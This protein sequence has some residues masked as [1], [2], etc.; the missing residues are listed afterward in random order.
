MKKRKTKETGGAGLPMVAG[1]ERL[2]RACDILSCDFAVAFNV[3]EN[4]ILARGDVAA[5]LCEILTCDAAFNDGDIERELRRIAPLAIAERHKEMNAAF[6]LHNDAPEITESNIEDFMF[7][8]RLEESSRIARLFR[9]IE[10]T[11]IQYTNDPQEIRARETA[12]I[13]EW[14]TREL[15]RA[16]GQWLYYSRAESIAEMAGELRRECAAKKWETGK[17]EVSAAFVTVARL[18][19]IAFIAKAESRQGAAHGCEPATGA[20]NPSG[21]AGGIVINAPIVKLNAGKVETPAP[22]EKPA[23][24]SKGFSQADFAALLKHY[25]GRFDGEPYKVR[26]IKEWDA[27]T[28]KRPMAGGVR[29]SPDLRRDIVAARK[30][31]MDFNAESQARWNARKAGL[32]RFG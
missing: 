15:R 28:E 11:K 5:K 18:R 1:V 32:R 21:N 14:N 2:R 3:C 22:K 10:E 23:G 13:V 29:Y 19:E 12:F 30:W 4:D 17:Q 24:H 31:A 9:G 27:H 26:A 16:I 7:D 25:G 8:F 20:A 6:G